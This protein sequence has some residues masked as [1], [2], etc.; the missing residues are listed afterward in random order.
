MT[1]DSTDIRILSATA[2]AGK[3]HPDFLISFF[4]HICN[5]C[6][7]LSI[8]SL[9]RRKLLKWE[10]DLLVPTDEGLKY[11][12]LSQLFGCENLNKSYKAPGP[13]NGISISAYLNKIISAKPLNQNTFNHT[14]RFLLSTG[15]VYMAD[16]RFVPDIPTVLRLTT[17]TNAHLAFNL[18]ESAFG[19]EAS[20]AVKDFVKTIS[21]CPTTQAGMLSMLNFHLLLCA[22]QAP[23]GGIAEL[24]LNLH[25]IVTDG[26]AFAINPLL[27]ETP[28][29]RT[30][31]FECDTDMTIR[32]TEDSEIPKH[33]WL[34][35]DNEKM[36]VVSE[37]T[38]TRNGLFRA[39]DSG[40]TVQNI[41]TELK[42]DIYDQILSQWES[43]YNRIR[44]YDSCVVKCS[45]DLV[46]VFENLPNLKD[47]VICRI[48]D[49]VYLMKKSTSRAWHEILCNV[50]HLEHLPLS[51]RESTK[52]APETTFTTGESFNLCNQSEEE[53][54]ITN[55]E[56]DESR[57]LEYFNIGN[58][59]TA[60]GMDYNGKNAIIRNA[61]R[62]GRTYL[63]VE[64]LDGQFVAKPVEVIKTEDKGNMVKVL[65]LPNRGE[66]LIAV[67][68]IYRV[69]SLEAFSS[70]SSSR[71]S[72]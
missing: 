40:L 37:W 5:E 43:S 16:D 61:V 70:H 13:L 2:L 51:I 67:S 32:I 35:C 52:P 46:P 64:T 42:T 15:A 33:I 8:E 36:D 41:K 39:L 14:K 22:S 63:L 56:T 30:K 17:M 55:T 23:A 48:T 12:K 68:S 38:L 66:K 20:N 53:Y 69:T 50:C 19:K 71:A 4:S 26:N 34:Y 29:E 44:V 27:R 9:V 3:A 65:I 6:V 28:K 1:I 62:S 11:S 24:L 60:T 72:F 25:T 31:P 7:I 10:R 47:H 57:L 54:E 59:I 45:E 58:T 18:T 49:C 21:K